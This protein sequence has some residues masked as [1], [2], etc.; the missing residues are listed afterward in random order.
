MGKGC[1]LW[2]WEESS[3]SV[4]CQYLVWA[5]VAMLGE[6]TIERLHIF[7]KYNRHDFHKDVKVH[8]F[9]SKT[10]NIVTHGKKAWGNILELGCFLLLLLLLLSSSQ[11][12]VAVA[13]K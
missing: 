1:A 9:I 6:K 4:K 13:T 12:Q 7:I 11:Q 2:G 8:V 3:L 10:S 5:D